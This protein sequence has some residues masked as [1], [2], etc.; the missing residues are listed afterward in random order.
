MTTEQLL[1]NIEECRERMIHLAS[2]STMDNHRVVEASTELD[3][4]INQ[5][6][7]LTKKQ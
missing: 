1:R 2:Y 4:L 3:Q 5:Y 6:L 7:H